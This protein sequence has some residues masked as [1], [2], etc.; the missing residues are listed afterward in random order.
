M[1][2]VAAG[3]FR[4]TICAPIFF[5]TTINFLDRQVISLLKG[6]LEICFNWT[7]SDYSNIIIAFQSSYAL[8]MLGVGRL[9]DKLGSKKGYAISVLFWSI[10]SKAHAL[11]TS[12]V[13]FG[14]ARAALGIT[15]A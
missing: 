13:G 3:N 10:A 7:E 15:E 2:K 4:W 8:G 5:V 1:N 11:A 6:T 9:I 12:T 14:M